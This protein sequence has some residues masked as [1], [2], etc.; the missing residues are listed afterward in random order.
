[1]KK[2]IITQIQSLRIVVKQ[3]LTIES[4]HLNVE[5]SEDVTHIL[6]ALDSM[7]QL[8]VI[9]DGVNKTDDE[10]MQILHDLTTPINGIIGYLYILEQ[11]YS[12]E[13]LTTKQQQLVQTIS[14]KIN[15]LYQFIS[16]Q[17]LSPQTGL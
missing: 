9:L 11:G 16:S 1:M 2:T 17:L 3:L 6:N 12:G 7:E 15:S 13:P 5:Q 14:V 4:T 10:R 8:T